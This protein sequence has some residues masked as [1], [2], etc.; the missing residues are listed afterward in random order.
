MYM[1]GV[2][3]KVTTFGAGLLIGTALIVIIPEGMEALFGEGVCIC[4]I[5][6]SD[7]GIDFIKSPST[8]TESSIR[9]LYERLLTAS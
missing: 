8:H 6:D 3:R 9:L 7:L 2:L 1:Q 4:F 5:S